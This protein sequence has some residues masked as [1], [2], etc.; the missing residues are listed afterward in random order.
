MSFWIIGS[1]NG[2]K[3]KTVEKTTVSGGS[4]KGEVPMASLSLIRMKRG[5]TTIDVTANL[6]KLCQDRQTLIK[7][8]DFWGAHDDGY[9]FR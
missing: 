9:F 7:K 6:A 4:M 1:Q 5:L 3:K 2:T 8:S